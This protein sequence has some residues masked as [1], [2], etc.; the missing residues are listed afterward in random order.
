MIFE[1]LRR[2]QSDN[3]DSMS[4]SDED[5][6]QQASST[7]ADSQAQVEIQSDLTW[8]DSRVWELLDKNKQTRVD[9]L[10][11]NNLGK[12]HWKEIVDHVNKSK[13]SKVQVDYQ[14]IKNKFDALKKKFKVE[15]TKRSS[16]FKQLGIL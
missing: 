14:Q 4:E 9:H 8:P 13:T 10:I 3:I 16:S 6:V 2:S 1:M 5:Q 12:K 11:N 7:V 15:K